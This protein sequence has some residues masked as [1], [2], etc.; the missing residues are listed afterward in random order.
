M[1]LDINKINDQLVQIIIHALSGMDDVYMVGG[2]V[3]D[4]LLD[5][6]NSDLDLM[7][8]AKD[9]K[10]KPIDE[11]V[12]N[13][14]V[15]K[16]KNIVNKINEYIDKNKL[17]EKYKFKFPSEPRLSNQGTLTLTNGDF[18]LDIALSRQEHYDLKSRKPSVNVSSAEIDSKRRDFTLNSLM[19]KLKDMSIIDYTGQGISDLRNGILRTP[20]DPYQTFLDDPLRIL[21]AIRMRNRFKKADG[22]SFELDPS[23]QEVFKNKDK[24][25]TLLSRFGEGQ[26][27]SMERLQEEIGKM[28]KSPNFGDALDELKEMAILDIP[29]ENFAHALNKTTVDLLNRFGNELNEAQRIVVWLKDV[30]IDKSD[31]RVMKNKIREILK[32]LK[33]KNDV[34]EDVVKVLSEVWKVNKQFGK[35]VSDAQVR[36]MVRDFDKKYADIVQI[37][38]MIYKG[39]EDFEQRVQT[40]GGVEDIQSPL[41]SIRGEDVMRWGAKGKDIGKVLMEIEYIAKI[42]KPEGISE[43]VIKSKLDSGEWKVV[44]GKVTENGEPVIDKHWK[45]L[46]AMTVKLKKI[47]NDLEGYG[48]YKEA[49]DIDEIL[50][51]RQHP[52]FKSIAMVSKGISISEDEAKR[53]SKAIDNFVSKEMRSSL[54][55]IIPRIGELFFDK[56]GK[57]IPHGTPWHKEDMFTHVMNVTEKL[58]VNEIPEL[59]EKI[60]MFLAGLLHDVGKPESRAFVEESGAGYYNEDEREG[61]YKYIGHDIKGAHIASEILS[62]LDIGGDIASSVITL[63]RHHMKFHEVIDNYQT[64]PNALNLRSLNKFI[65]KLP[66]DPQKTFELL[67]RLDKADSEGSEKDVEML[68]IMGHNPYS[69]E[70]PLDIGVQIYNAYVRQQAEALEKQKLDMA[71][72]QTSKDVLSEDILELISKEFGRLGEFSLSNKVSNVDPDTLT[73]SQLVSKLYGGWFNEVGV[74]DKDRMEQLKR[75]VLQI[76]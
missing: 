71:L 56:S 74:S 70:K 69:K 57:P 26:K 30:D 22:T 24:M 6:Q 64:N 73:R 55:H 43:E 63:V 18:H 9:F 13:F 66:G 12:Q 50:Q 58:N 48:M 10:G 38:N 28:A 11:E 75:I 34:I 61:R 76:R 8:E 42:L 45:H 3:R 2:I 49:K 15:S 44:N 53:I 46:N 16:A 5:K 31:S 37:L 21:R 17:P 27:V 51:M 1:K 52:L 25:V 68:K 60:I 35:E 67:G 36:R 40:L 72:R 62:S 59:K 4:Y 47:A 29:N 20:L 19:V 23:I 39:Y 14:L 41:V 7:I 65:S 32:G 33:Y 54:Q